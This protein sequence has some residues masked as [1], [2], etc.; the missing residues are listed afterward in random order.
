[1][2]LSLKKYFPKFKVNGRS[3]GKIV[4]EKGNVPKSRRHARILSPTQHHLLLYPPLGAIL[5]W[6]VCFVNW[7]DA[8]KGEVNTLGNQIKKINSIE[9]I[10]LIFLSL[11]LSLPIAISH[12]KSDCRTISYLFC[13][14]YDRSGKSIICFVIIKI[15]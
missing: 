15:L 9:L 7:I 3:M 5:Q 6:S 4:N 10:Q 2:S 14:D 13:N 8:G 12:E 1:M 11:S